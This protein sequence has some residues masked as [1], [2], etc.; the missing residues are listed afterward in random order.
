MAYSD[1]TVDMNQRKYYSQKQVDEMEAYYQEKIKKNKFHFFSAIKKRK[2]NEKKRLLVYT[3][4]GIVT[5][6]VITI[7]A[8]KLG[9]KVSEMFYGVEPYMTEDTVMTYESL[10][11]PGN[12][13][14]S[15]IAYEYYNNELNKEAFDSPGQ[16]EDYIADR[17][18]ILNKDKIDE[19]DV[20]EVPVVISK[21][22]YDKQVRKQFIEEYQIENDEIEEPKRIK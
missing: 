7:G 11:I 15:H 14:L 10:T 1:K 4:G 17:N 6:V 18:R 16:L 8:S 20:L 12:E 21:E 19:G 2:K 5:G 13:T 3:I 22:E 9:E